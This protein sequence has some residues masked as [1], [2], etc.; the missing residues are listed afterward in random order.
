MSKYEFEQRLDE[1]KY[2][3]IENVK[4]ILNCWAN[5]EIVVYVDDYEDFYDDVDETNYDPYM[6]CDFYDCG[7]YDEW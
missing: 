5:G 6:G 3:L 4:A 7:S 1:T 2:N